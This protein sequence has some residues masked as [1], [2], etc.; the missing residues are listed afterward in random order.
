MDSGTGGG[1]HHIV[2]RRDLRQRNRSPAECYE[3]CG[4][5][6]SLPPPAAEAPA[7]VSGSI[8]RPERHP[9]GTTGNRNVQLATGRHPQR[10][11]SLLRRGDRRAETLLSDA[12]QTGLSTG[13]QRPKGCCGRLTLGLVAGS[14]TQAT[15]RPDE[16]S[17]RGNRRVHPHRSRFRRAAARALMAG[18][19]RGRSRHHY[20]HHKEVDL[21]TA[22]P[23]RV[24]CAQLSLLSS[25]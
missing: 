2:E 11:F 15:F 21:R 18:S 3:K 5:R 12:L 1:A 9:T 4:H 23:M 8:G 22:L 19:T 6:Q 24:Q 14:R 13:S 20:A 16:R 10:R 25:I 17:P 7:A